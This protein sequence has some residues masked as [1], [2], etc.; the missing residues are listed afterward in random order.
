[1]QNSHASDA[2]GNSRDTWDIDSN[3][4]SNGTAENAVEPGKTGDNVIDGHDKGG[5][6][7]HDPASIEDFD[8]AVYMTDNTVVLNNYG[9]DVT[10]TI[11]M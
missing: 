6:D 7:D 2:D 11:E 5:E 9:D 8:L 3:P 1:M 4:G 10:F